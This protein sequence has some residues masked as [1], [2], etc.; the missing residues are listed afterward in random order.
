M[1]RKRLESAATAYPHMRG[2]LG[3]PAGLLFVV[4]GLSNMK[5][6]PFGSDWLFIA[7]LAACGLAG[8]GLLRYYRETY[9]NFTSSSRNQ[10]KVT[11][12]VGVAAAVFVAVNTLTYSEGRSISILAASYGLIILAYYAIFVGL[13]AHHVLIAG[14]LVVAG[15]LPIWGGLGFDR[16]SVSMVVMGLATVAMGVFDHLVLV[17][18]FAS[19]GSPEL[20]RSDASA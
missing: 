7:C 10:M 1:D 4:A 20:E 13:K 6:G 12:V 19:I 9:G 11:A 18:T 16:D 2:L 15:L 17:R 14:G 5:W 8:F 3:V